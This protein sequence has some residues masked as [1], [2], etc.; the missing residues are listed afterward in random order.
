MLLHIKLK[1][2][3]KYVVTVHNL[4]NLLKDFETTEGIHKG[5]K[6]TRTQT[7]FNLL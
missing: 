1:R 5:V 4:K 2:F 3:Q 6:K 7:H